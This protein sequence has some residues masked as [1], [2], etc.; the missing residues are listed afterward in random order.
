GGHGCL[1]LPLD[2]PPGGG[3]A[4]SS[5]DREAERL[6][7]PFGAAGAQIEEIGLQQRL[8]FDHQSIAAIRE[9]NRVRR[10]VAVLLRH[11]VHP[12]LGRNLEMPVSRHQIVLPR[13]RILP[14]VQFCH[15]ERSEAISRQYHSVNRD[16]FVAVLLAMTTSFRLVLH[17][18]TGGRAVF[19]TLTAARAFDFLHLVQV[20]RFEQGRP[21][22][23][24]RAHLATE[25]AGI[26]DR[27]VDPHLHLMPPTWCNKY[28]SASST[29]FWV[30]GVAHRKSI[31]NLPS[32]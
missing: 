24:F 25:T 10:A 19:E 17:Q 12:A 13:H 8:P 5:G 26:A 2:P 30:S 22:R 11:P 21:D 18:R 23:R 16:C 20:P 1:T 27:V 31:W 9:M 6:P 29:G 15:C 14:L 4:G 28:P 32:M 3:G 7:C